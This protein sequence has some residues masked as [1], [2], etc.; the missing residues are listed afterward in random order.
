MAKGNPAAV[1]LT[2]KRAGTT[3]FSD[4][5]RLTESKFADALAKIG[6]AG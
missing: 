6:V 4:K 3:D 5:R 2:N 1:D